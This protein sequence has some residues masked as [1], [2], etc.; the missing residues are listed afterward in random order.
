[1]IIAPEQYDSVK[2]IEGYENWSPEDLAAFFEDYGL[3]D[4]REVL[5][6]HK[7]VS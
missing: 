4:Y 7:I 5:I 6:H 3:G 1:M 2:F